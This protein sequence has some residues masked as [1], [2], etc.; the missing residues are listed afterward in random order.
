MSFRRKQHNRLVEK[1]S[2]TQD[3]VRFLN[4]I[5]ILH[6]KESENCWS[7]L[8]PSPQL[9]K[10]VN[11]ATVFFTLDEHTVSPQ[12]SNK[13]TPINYTN[14]IPKCQLTI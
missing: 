12:N 10:T 7:D 11:E 13:F 6:K 2:W 3:N 4:L 5:S 8:R 14:V 1:Q 9:S